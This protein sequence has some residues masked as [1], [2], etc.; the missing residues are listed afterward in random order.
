V[1]T[2]HDPPR[3]RAVCANCGRQLSLEERF[4]FQGRVFC[5]ACCIDLRFTRGRKTHWQYLG[6][7]KADYLIPAR[8]A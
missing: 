8:K 3:N 1:N 2:V 7:I 5:E 6:S 4:P